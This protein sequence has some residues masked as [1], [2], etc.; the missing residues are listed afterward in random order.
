MY[1]PG[2]VSTYLPTIPYASCVLRRSTVAAIV[3]AHRRGNDYIFKPGSPCL[4]PESTNWTRCSPETPNHL[5]R[6]DDLCVCIYIQ[7]LLGVILSTQ[8]T[9]GRHVCV[10]IKYA[11]CHNQYTGHTH[12]CTFN[13]HWT[14]A[15]VKNGKHLPLS[16]TKSESQSKPQIAPRGSAHFFFSCI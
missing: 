7:N 1:S 14:V 8:T 5:L 15:E 9:T 11:R 2:L 13:R 4:S 10:Y 12:P 3:A 16:Q 6:I